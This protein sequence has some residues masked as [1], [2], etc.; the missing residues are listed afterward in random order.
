LNLND[1]NI[2]LLIQKSKD[3][4]NAINDIKEYTNVDLEEFLR[5]NM[6]KDSTKYKLIVAIEGS[7][8]ICNHIASRLGKRVPESYS[9]CFEIISELGVI[10]EE[11][12]KKL[13][14]MSKFRHVLIH[15]YWKIDDNKI[16]EIAK[17][18]VKDLL[19]FINQLGKFLKEKK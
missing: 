6:V 19:E 12:T 4:R 7:I 11:L 3:I 14:N 18:N 17:K 16:F 15:L 13:V 2:D 1:L 10:S 5:N 9:D 8:T